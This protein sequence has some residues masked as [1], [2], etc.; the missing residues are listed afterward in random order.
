VR[1]DA[2][3]HVA[4]E[5]YVAVLAKVP[6]PPGTPEFTLPHAEAFMRRYEIDAAVISTGPPGV[7]FGDQ[8]RANDLARALNERYAQIVAAAPDR[9]AALATL[10]LPDLDASI[11]ELRHALDELGLDGV[12][13]PSNV[14]GGYLGD[15]R[16]DPLLGELDA[17]GAYVLVHPF[18]PPYQA[19]L[20]RWPVWLIEFPFETTRAIV[21]LI[22]S[23]TF[24]RY[25]SIRFQ[26]SH[27]GGTAPFLAERIGS[28]VARESRFRAAIAHEPAHYLGRVWYDTALANAPAGLAA[29]A[30]VA[31]GERIVFGTDWPY[32]ALPEEGGDPAPA[33]AGLGS[34]RA[35]VDGANIGALVPRFQAKEED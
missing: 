9:F 21:N 30:Q 2:H 10:P 1:I 35:G 4:P 32:A 3:L 34:A 18:F 33:L 14:A 26:F 6:G 17:R 20:E 5:E 29:A 11:D 19:P 27:L 25:P 31:A 22:Y 15:E 28:L 13:L 23:G 24:D 8:Q 7:F 12:W 16:L